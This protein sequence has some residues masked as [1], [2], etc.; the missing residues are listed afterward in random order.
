MRSTFDDVLLFLPVV[1][2]WIHIAILWRWTT[3]TPGK[4]FAIGTLAGLMTLTV[5]YLYGSELLNIRWLQPLLLP[6]DSSQ[7]NRAA[8]FALGV[9]VGYLVFGVIWVRRVSAGAGKWSA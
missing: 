1:V 5:E 7:M 3:W 8:P 2:A 6:V 9:F 4:C